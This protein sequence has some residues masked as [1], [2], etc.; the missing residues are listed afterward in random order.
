[1]SIDVM[2]TGACG[3]VGSHLAP[4]LARQGH[5]VTGTFY[6]PTTE[7]PAN[8]E[9][10]SLLEMDIRYPQNV[11]RMLA[12]FRPK[13]IYHL[14]AQ[15]YPTVSWE[16]PQE[17]MDTNVLGT[18]NL[19]EA[20]RTLRAM[21]P[22]YD[23]MVVAACSSAQYGASLLD[24]TGPVTEDAAFL[25]LHPYGVSKVATD[26]L[27]FQYFRSDGIRS[28]RARI[29]NT[30]GPRKTGDVISDFARRIAALPPA[31]GVLRV[32][33]LSTRRAFLHVDDL[34]SALTVLA[35]KGQP[36]E[37]YNISGAE[38]VSIGDLIPMFEAVAGCP[39]TPDVD[40]SLLRPTDEPI[41]I[42]SNAKITGATGWVPKRNVREL[43]AD[44]YAWEK[45]RRN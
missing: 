25:P 14:A 23:P 22:G 35:A 10:F 1:M 12:R 32:G 33:N 19:Y 24:A 4:L 29:F 2:I 8:P 37:A 5:S 17:T 11:A 3:M 6:R 42:G 16:R 41:I 31:G 44:V 20:I 34:I 15:S 40:K 21:D 27:A 9:G 26:L 39:I 30:S 45:G 43:V 13:T 36:G 28:I 38:I 18:V 7:L